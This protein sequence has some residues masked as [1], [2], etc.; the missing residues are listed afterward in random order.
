MVF[1]MAR[2]V[3]DK[4]RWAYV[5]AMGRTLA[6][7][8]KKA[9]EDGTVK[10]QH[11]QQDQE[12]VGGL[13]LFLAVPQPWPMRLKESVVIY[14]AMRKMTSMTRLDSVFEWAYEVD[15]DEEYSYWVSYLRPSIYGQDIVQYIPNLE[16][17]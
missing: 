8:S 13:Y 5:Q 11:T 3:N 16:A 2:W 14:S 4:A 6:A 9:Y 10:I 17:S 15:E 1:K 12:H 7:F